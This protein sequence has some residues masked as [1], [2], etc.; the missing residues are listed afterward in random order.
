MIV[1]GCSFEDAQVRVE[2]FSLYGSDII[3]DTYIFQGSSFIGRESSESSIK[4]E[5]RNYDS[6]GAVQ[7][8][9]T[10]KECSFINVAPAT[11]GSLHMTASSAS[12]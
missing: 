10:I 1:Q 3:S 7:A 5:D 9:V 2:V 8:S 12:Y 4:V 6:N 11:F